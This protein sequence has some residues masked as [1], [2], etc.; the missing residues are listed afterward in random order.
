MLVNPWTHMVPQP[1]LLVER[2]RGPAGQS[3]GPGRNRAGGGG[4][5]L[6]LSLHLPP[7]LHP[8][9]DGAQAWLL[10]AGN[11]GRWGVE[12]LRGGPCPSL[13]PAAPTPGIRTRKGS[14]G[15]GGIGAPLVRMQKQGCRMPPTVPSSRTQ[16][17][18]AWFGCRGST[19]PG[20]DREEHR[21]TV[22][23]EGIR[24][25][26]SRPA[27]SLFHPFSPL[28]HMLGIVV[29]L[30]TKRSRG[31]TGQRRGPTGDWV[32][33]PDCGLPGG[34]QVRGHCSGAGRRG[35]AGSSASP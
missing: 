25:G 7:A 20:M 1:Q 32:G 28:H 10:W 15:S 5:S 6:G 18:W 30:Q 35:S 4:A 21:S 8:T 26:S 23:Q 34:Q 3:G 24:A 29:F 11:L 17:V 9:C 12:E 13:P 2:V 31:M 33:A 19:G 22:P 16:H 27:F 14:P